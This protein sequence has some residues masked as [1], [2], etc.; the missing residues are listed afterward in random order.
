MDTRLP[1]FVSANLL[2]ARQKGGANTTNAAARAF[3]AVSQSKDDELCCSSVA[4]TA[5]TANAKNDSLGSRG[6]ALWRLA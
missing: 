2:V 5:T 4:P 6:Y 3:I 1:A